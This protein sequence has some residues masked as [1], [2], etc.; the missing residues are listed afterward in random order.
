MSGEDTDITPPTIDQRRNDYI[1]NAR[2]KLPNAQDLS[3]QVFMT[4]S[5]E[6]SE[7]SSRRAS[8]SPKAQPSGLLAGHKDEEAA[9]MDPKSG[10]DWSQQ[11]QRGSMRTA[12]PMA[13]APLNQEIKE[14]GGGPRRDDTTYRDIVLQKDLSAESGLT[15][16]TFG[17]SSTAGAVG[18]GLR[19]PAPDRTLSAPA[20]SRLGD[21][22]PP[23][24][25][26]HWGA[27]RGSSGGRVNGTE[28]LGQ[29][30]IPSHPAFLSKESQR[31]REV[32][33]NSIE[34]GQQQ[35]KDPIASAAAASVSSPSSSSGSSLS[36]TKFSALIA[37]TLQLPIATLLQLIPPQMLDPSHER[38]SST[39]LHLPVTSVEALLEC[40]KTVNWLCSRAV[41]GG[42]GEID[43]S[44]GREGKEDDS[45][46][47]EGKARGS[48]GTSSASLSGDREGASWLSAAQSSSSLS[49][50]S[51]ISPSSLALSQASSIKGRRTDF[52][53]FELVQRVADIVS[54]QA[55][56][57]GVNVVLL[58]S[59]CAHRTGSGCD[60]SDSQ[61]EEK[62]DKAIECSISGDEGAI[63]FGIIHVRLSC[64]CI[65]NLRALNAPC[66]VSQLLSRV[67]SIAP[68]GSELH[69]RMGTSIS[70]SSTDEEEILDATIEAILL[71]DIKIHPVDFSSGGSAC[72]AVL[73]EAGLELH[74]GDVKELTEGKQ[75]AESVIIARTGGPFSRGNTAGT[76]GAE[77]QE[78]S[79]KQG[80][81][82]PDPGAHWEVKH[83]IKFS[84]HAGSKLP[85]AADFDE[86]EHAARQR[87]LPAIT[88]GREPTLREL[89]HLMKEELKG[90][91]VAVHA[92]ADSIFAS[93]LSDLLRYSGCDVAR[94]PLQD[95]DESVTKEYWQDGNNASGD[96][97]VTHATGTPRTAVAI[98]KG[99]PLLVN[100]PSD[101]SIPR[102]LDAAQ[103][104]NDIASPSQTSSA[105]L[106]PITGE[107]APLP[108]A[109]S[110]SEMKRSPSGD[111]SLHRI[112]PFSFL[113]I[114]DD[115][116]TLQVELLRIRS[117]LPLLQS[118]LNSS[119]ASSPT[120][121]RP[122]LGKRLHSNRQV[123]R[124]LNQENVFQPSQQQSGETSPMSPE[125]QG[126]TSAIIYFTSLSNFRMVRDI[127]RPISQSMS[128]GMGTQ[129]P[130]IIV[131]PK[132]AGIRRLLTTLHTALHKPLVDPFFHPIATSPM[133]PAVLS[134]RARPFDPFI[135][136]QNDEQGPVA[137]SGK[138]SKLSSPS[139]QPTE[140]M[141]S[142]GMKLTSSP[143]LEETPPSPEE[144]PS[145]NK[146]PNLHLGRLP[147]AG[148]NMERERSLTP[149]AGASNASNG[150]LTPANAESVEPGGNFSNNTS[151][152]STTGTQS[153]PSSPV[154]VDA[155]EYFGE[156]ASRM[157]SSAATGMVVQS[158]DGRPAGIYF[159]PKSNSIRS[160]TSLRSGLGV[161]SER[162]VPGTMNRRSSSNS[163]RSVSSSKLEHGIEA[164][165]ANRSGTASSVT[166]TTPSFGAL[167][168]PQVGIEH[169]LNGPAP[170]VVGPLPRHLAEATPSIVSSPP[171]APPSA[172][173]S[174]RGLP[175]SAA[176]SPS[177][178]FQQRDDQDVRTQQPP[179]PGNINT[180]VS[181]QSTLAPEAGL[182]GSPLRPKPGKNPL[183]QARQSFAMAQLPSRDGPRPSAQPQAGLLIGAGFSQ[184]QRRGTGQR[185]APVREAVLPPIKVLIVEGQSTENSS[186]GP[187]LLTLTL[188]Q[189]TPS[190]S[191]FWRGS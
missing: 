186:D 190:I 182:S 187:F 124:I 83:S 51:A 66:F 113:M 151:A 134:G 121:S 180:S 131:V 136:G 165:R 47:P 61:K 150:L 50:T 22:K 70:S 178:E 74:S 14:E 84:V 36:S 76:R 42:A 48:E 81:N 153:R 43:R 181:P 122:P 6:S 41:R 177:S 188:L 125:F 130:E 114:D 108:S 33:A 58:H 32:A 138:P 95:A 189:T 59:W 93:Q 29:L 191:A 9:G 90:K 97:S 135:V 78:Q 99:R 154:S 152:K 75:D 7:S 8:P 179:H 91:K 168:T 172:S 127:V 88:V 57:K 128:L 35:R 103:T 170:P 96:P 149:K 110:A 132:P 49:A 86:A 69:I 53:L 39:S 164:A 146:D 40:Y 15:H 148:I 28:E 65:I 23:T 45:G 142:N 156:A 44:T 11:A 185:R 30:E 115:I 52:D 92:S 25:V 100:Y 56:S 5:Q 24:D 34:S 12:R 1:Y 173:G 107:P 27:S 18:A 137:A 140:A 38:F 21:L 129:L 98:S 144:Q 89:Q 162:V 16:E 109:S 184:A 116:R 143:R 60:C 87:F 62:E 13:E 169:V 63:R 126:S 166:S 10:R 159:R 77:L 145:S 67:I 64:V 117:A 183:A 46:T 101:V 147:Q 158:P 119:A 71:A 55:A 141:Q 105:V 120:A 17:T 176:S 160:V 102:S 37:D 174:T 80:D 19:R 85:E 79:P 26:G 167:L 54:G 157:G 171:Q 20:Y 155:L 31:S 94:L 3:S 82:D 68:T 111:S 73:T 175:F 72:H 106:N 163:R 112:E 123:D 4:D 133:S 2:A 104:G 139:S 118:A 161:S